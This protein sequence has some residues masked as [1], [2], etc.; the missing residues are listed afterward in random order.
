MNSQS[1]GNPC[2]VRHQLQSDLDALS[3][4]LRKANDILAMAAESPDTL[5]RRRNSIKR[6]S[7]IY[8]EALERLNV[9]TR[10][11]RCDQSTLS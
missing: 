11:H 4:A 7:E 8:L 6:W 3:L 1:P 10:E 5:R 2:A 9:H